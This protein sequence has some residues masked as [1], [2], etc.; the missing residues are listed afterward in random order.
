M[1]S[2]IKFA[3]INKS[4]NIL[5]SEDDAIHDILS[6]ALIVMV[7]SNQPTKEQCCKKD[8]EIIELTLRIDQTE[9]LNLFDVGIFW[10]NYFQSENFMLKLLQKQ[11]LPNRTF[12]AII[13]RSCKLFCRKIVSKN[14]WIKYN[15]ILQSNYSIFYYPENGLWSRVTNRGIWGFSIDIDTL[16]WRFEHLDCGCISINGPTRVRKWPILGPVLNGERKLA[17]LPSG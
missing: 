6:S 12:F 1:T 15:L 10:N 7:T 17:N 8:F 11:P 4:A 16:N 9:H 5:L 2:M 3:S 14:H 13:N